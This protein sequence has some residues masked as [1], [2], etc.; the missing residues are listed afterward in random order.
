MILNQKPKITIHQSYIRPI[1]EYASVIYDNCT[2]TLSDKLEGV[3]RQAALACT[4]A[5][6]STSHNALLAE[7]GWVRLSVRRECQKL[8]HM[9]KMQHGLVPRHLSGICPPL[10]QQEITYNLRRSNQIQLPRCR[11]TLFF[12]SF[13]PST[14]RLWNGLDPPL[15]SLPTLSRFKGNIRLSRLVR[16]NKLYIVGHGYGAL[17]LGRIRMGLSALNVHRRK[18][19]FINHSNCPNCTATREDPVHFFLDCPRYAAPR[20]TLLAS[21]ALVPL[22]LPNSPR[23]RKSFVHT[24][25][26]GSPDL[27][28]E[29]NYEI[30]RNVQLYIN[31]TR[32][33]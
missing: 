14:I 29:H 28:H 30:I 3:Q 32:R 31:S 2:M 25:T 19:N 26:H 7:L 4:G 9:Y 11:T 23:E 27:T 5:Y 12:K 33:F 21:L 22:Q 18:Y 20:Q 13:L 15:R 1:L 16:T 17:N 8:F 10:T 6:A 24:L